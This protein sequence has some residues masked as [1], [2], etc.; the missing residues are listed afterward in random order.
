MFRTMCTAA[1]IIFILVAAPAFG[2]LHTFTIDEGQSTVSFDVTGLGG[3]VVTSGVE[4][5]FVLELEGSSPDW[6]GRV[7]M[8]TVNAWNLELINLLN[9]YIIQPGNLKLLDFDENDN[10]FGT[11]SG[12][13]IASG[14]VHTGVYVKAI[15]EGGVTPLDEWLDPVDW[16]VEVSDD[17]YIGSKEPGW[18]PEARLAMTGAIGSD[19][20]NIPFSVQLVGAQVP[21][22]GTMTILLCGLLVGLPVALRRHRR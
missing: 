22:P 10:T 6:S 13:P 1:V 8:E 2:D 17:N 11:L 3:G 19:A 7:E 12:T 16:T 18:S 20:G 5:T 9:V 4:G 15:F 21:E 14:T